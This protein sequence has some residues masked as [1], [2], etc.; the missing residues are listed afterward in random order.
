[1]EYKKSRNLP[2]PGDKETWPRRF[3]HPNVDDEPDLCCPECGREWGHALYCP[4]WNG[5]VKGD[6]NA[7]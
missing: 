7:F 1:M 3:N 2:G 6:K 5:N 4:N